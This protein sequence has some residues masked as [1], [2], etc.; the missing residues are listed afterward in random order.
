MNQ[1]QLLQLVAKHA[2]P[3]RA[4]SASNNSLLPG[5]GFCAVCARPI[6][7]TYC[8]CY[9]CDQDQKGEYGGELADQVIT[10]SY[11]VKGHSQKA[12]FYSDLFRYKDDQPSRVAQ[13]R[14]L[15][16]VALTRMAHSACFVSEGEFSWV[17]GVPSTRG[18]KTLLVE[19]SRVLM[20]DVDFL[21]TRF[22][23]NPAVPRDRVLTPDAF[24]ISH[25]ISGRVLVVEDTWVT[26][27]NA[28]SLAIQLKRAGASHVTI[29]TLARLLDYR[30][31]E[32]AAYI[33]GGG[34]DHD[35]GLQ[36]CPVIQRDCTSL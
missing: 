32:T 14:L 5:T 18:R 26:G 1:E 4:L 28:Q 25:R 2:S 15:A 35:W 13:N 19:L 8:Q 10:L 23:G 20:P 27:S 33:N 11:A 36:P 22:V 12:Q 16:M 34:I 7:A 31:R 17:T 24:E 3:P 29:V 6:L 21:E 9:R 30:D